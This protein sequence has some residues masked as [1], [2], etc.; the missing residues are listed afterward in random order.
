[1]PHRL[2]A[3][4]F[5]AIILAACGSRPAA[6]AGSQSLT[7][8]QAAAVQADVRTFAN[9]VARDITEDG[10]S[11]WRRHFSD[12]PSF[13]MVAEGAMAF[14]NSAAA[15]AGIQDLARTIKHIELKWGDDLRVDPLTL[16]I[17]V[18]AASW[19]EVHVDAAGKRV[20][21]AGFFTA[22][23][24]RRDGQWKF[25]DVHWSWPESGPAARQSK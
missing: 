23:A 7:A 21:E 22:I 6:T 11:A 1:M 20:D 24:E 2:W 3:L 12:S 16:D 17:A 8:A 14:S 9:V 10:P 18:M 5:A 4:I 19:R 25:R 13:F 15:T